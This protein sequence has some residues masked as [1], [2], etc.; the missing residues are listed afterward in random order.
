MPFETEWIPSNIVLQRMVKHT[1]NA[2]RARVILNRAAKG[3]LLPAIAYGRLHEVNFGKIPLEPPKNL[4]NAQF[5][6]KI[7]EEPFQ[8]GLGFWKS[9]RR[10]IYE[11]T[12]WKWSL[13]VFASTS[14]PPN[15]L[16]R[17]VD[18]G[19][20]TVPAGMR[21]VMFDVC[22][23]AQAVEELL[24]KTPR[25]HGRSKPTGP[26]SWNWGTA[27]A[28]IQAQILEFG[29]VR[30][31]ADPTHHG[32][33][34]RIMDEFSDIMRAIY[35]SDPERCAGPSRASLGR[36]ADAVLKMWRAH[37]LSHEPA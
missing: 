1:G 16:I 10:S 36:E 28:Q 34:A 33:R 20:W 23:S 12:L 31:I 3:G 26:I 15:Q 17:D 24:D 35:A 7:Y 21:E 29:A 4:S 30:G 25:G 22:F 13:G 5:E 8:L 14:K 37:L 6:C 11:A 32:A 18:L 19:T 9:P 2:T 27:R